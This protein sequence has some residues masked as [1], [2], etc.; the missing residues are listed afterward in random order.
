MGRVGHGPEAQL[1][2]QIIAGSTTAKGAPLDS[3]EGIEN[4]LGGTLILTE[5]FE[6]DFEGHNLAARVL[7]THIV[8]R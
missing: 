2:N 5:E 7:S 8:A 3:T 4:L 6:G 1:A